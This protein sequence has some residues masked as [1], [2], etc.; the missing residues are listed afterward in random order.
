MG[1]NIG[2]MS[3][4]FEVD[5]KRERIIKGEPWSRLFNPL[6]MEVFSEYQQGGGVLF[7]ITGDLD[8]L[9]VYVARNGRPAAENLVDLY[10]QITRN[11]LEKY[12]VESES[13]IRTLSF[14]PS[15]EE[16]FIVG[17]ANNENAAKDLFSALREG[18]MELMQSQPYIDLGGTFGEF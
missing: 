14:V 13:N 10:N 3:K 1:Y 15:G 17:I 12:A 9:G 4:E 8:N 11:F 16:V 5:P 7:G 18:V 6:I 2:L